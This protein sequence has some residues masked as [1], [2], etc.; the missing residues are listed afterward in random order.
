MK[1]RIVLVDDHAVVR[2]GRK[3]L[4]EGQSDI[5]IVGEASDGREAIDRIVT[6]QPDV[7]V[8]DVSM[9]LISGAQATREVRQRCPKTKVLALTVHEDRSYMHEMLEAGAAGYLLKRAAGD[10]LVGAIRAVAASGVYVDPRIAG[11]LITALGS[12]RPASSDR[13]D[14]LSERETEVMRLI[15]QGFTNKEISAQLGVSVKTIETYKARSMEKLGL[16]SRVDIVRIATE[17]GWL[18][19]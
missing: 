8:M 11:K 16:R 14:V 2:E 7:A 1:L 13:R 6:L 15:A 19:R 17:R 12:S 9:G 5:D 10:E 4:L 3:R 18:N